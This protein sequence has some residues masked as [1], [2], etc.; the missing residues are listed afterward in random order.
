MPR[1]FAAFALLLVGLGLAGVSGSSWL[2]GADKFDRRAQS[3]RIL[4]SD[5]YRFL[6]YVETEAAIRGFQRQSDGDCA[7]AAADIND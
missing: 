1:W 2:H 3:D 4:T 7:G 5:M 6:R